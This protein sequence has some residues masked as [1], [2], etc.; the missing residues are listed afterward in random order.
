M[1]IIKSKDFFEENNIDKCKIFGY[2]LEERDMDICISVITGRYPDSG[3]CEH[4]VCKELIYVLEGSGKLCFEDKEVEF[5]QGDCVSI[6]PK[7]KYYWITDYCKVS[8]TCSP[9]WYKEQYKITE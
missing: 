4:L 6:S 8:I 9:A 7:E 5:S 3:Y 2:P 1:K